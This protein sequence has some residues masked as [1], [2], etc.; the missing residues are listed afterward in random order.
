MTLSMVE[1]GGPMTVPPMYLRSLWWA[2]ISWWTAAARRDA[3]KF[4]LLPCGE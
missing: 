2:A 1:T 3:V 4:G